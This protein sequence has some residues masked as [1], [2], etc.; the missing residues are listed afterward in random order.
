MPRC[1]RPT[2]C[3]TAIASADPGA[4][5][6]AS[7]NSRPRA[8]SASSL[9]RRGDAKLSHVLLQVGEYRYETLAR[10]FLAI[11]ILGYSDRVTALVWC[12]LAPLIVLT[13]CFGVEVF[14]GLRPLRAEVP[15]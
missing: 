5:G 1:R 13:L 10:S 11:A 2:Q 14:A 8:S 9:P 7:S 12:L 4:G 3:S 6:R 15:P